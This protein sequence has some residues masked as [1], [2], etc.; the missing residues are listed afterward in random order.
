MNK[1]RQAIFEK[2]GG[3]CL[4]CGC[5][6]AG[7]R[8]QAD[9]VHPII[10]HPEKGTCVHPEFDTDENLYP[11]C[12]P[13]NNF[14]SS[15]DVEGFR[16]KVNEQ[17]VNV[18]KYSTGARQLDRLGL[19]SIN[20]SDSIKFWFEVN[21]INVPTKL[22]LMGIKE[23]VWHKNNDEPDSYHT[24][25]NLGICSLRHIPNHGWL[26]IHTKADWEQDRITCKHCNLEAAKLKVTKWIIS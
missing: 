26:A 4:Y 12:G 14:K 21:D 13:C 6:L 2:T 5:D 9:H 24:E 3:K 20:S 7:T 1:K 19:L 11:S 18:L 8:W 25:T 16:R 22:E 10:R 23:L 15:Y 17:F